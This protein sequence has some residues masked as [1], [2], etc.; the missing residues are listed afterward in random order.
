MPSELRPRAKKRIQIKKP[1]DDKKKIE[2]IL[3]KLEEAEETEEKEAVSEEEKSEA[4]SAILESGEENFEDDAE[5]VG[6][7]FRQ[8]NS[9]ILILL[10]LPKDNDYAKDYFDNGEKFLDDSDDD[11]EGP[12]YH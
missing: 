7:K 5:E 12:T 4:G 2:K 1:E 9:K 11:E 10:F 3:T 6:K 8:Y